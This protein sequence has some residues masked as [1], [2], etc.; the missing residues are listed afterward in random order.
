LAQTAAHLVDRVFP[1]VGVRQ[2]VFSV[3]KLLRI[4]MAMS[5]DL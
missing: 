5:A 1:D 2:W 3:Q 4:A